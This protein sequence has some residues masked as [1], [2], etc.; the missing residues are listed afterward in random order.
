MTFFALF[1]A[2]DY[3]IKFSDFTLNFA[4]K[5]K[6]ENIGGFEE[7]GIVA[8]LDEERDWRWWHGNKY[9]DI[10]NKLKSTIDW[11][12]SFQTTIVW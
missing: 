12:I 5:I 11:E 1:R 9:N 8:E 10:G 7:R 2:I 4:F 3:A 6:K